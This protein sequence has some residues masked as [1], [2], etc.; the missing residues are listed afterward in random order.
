MPT[1][2]FGERVARSA[3]R[4][5]PQRALSDLIGWGVR[6]SVALPPSVRTPFLRSFART[7]GIAVD[8][9]E[10]PLEQYTGLQEFF[11]RRLKPGIRAIDPSADTVL[12]PADGTVSEVGRFADST[13][14]D[15][16]GTSFSLA[17]LVADGDLARALE[18]GSFQVTYLSPRDYHRVHSPV[19][20]DIVAWHYVP[21]KLFPVNTRSVLREPGLFAKNERF[22][23]VIEG[24]A[25][26]CALVM[27]AA[28]GV[29][30]ITASYDPDVETHAKGFGSASARHKRFTAPVSIKRGEELGTFNLGSTT[31][32]VFQRDRVILDPAT[33]G[34]STRMGS[35]M[36]RIASASHSSQ[37]G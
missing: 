15:A 5:T 16:K 22:V 27:V 34:A 21:G 23:T 4:V 28:V 2:S 7:Y 14:I 6:H 9:A 24:E 1:L 29:G 8:E 30:H 19:T 35:R 33:V 36:G 31:I 3:W 25:G 26:L 20:G 12:C 10:K 17:E 18:G 37:P 13:V 32:A 11:T